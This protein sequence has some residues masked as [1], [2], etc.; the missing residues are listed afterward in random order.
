MWNKTDANTATEDCL[1]ISPC[2]LALKAF[3]K[4]WFS[5]CLALFICGYVQHVLLGSVNSISVYEK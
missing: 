5:G 3:T 1:V 4:S 2:I